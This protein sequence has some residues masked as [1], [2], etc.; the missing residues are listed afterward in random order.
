[1]FKVVIADLEPIQRKSIRTVLQEGFRRQIIVFETD[2]GQEAYQL[3][4]DNQIDLVILDY[5]LIG[6]DGLT[7]L[8]RMKQNKP[9]QKVIVY[10]MLDD[11]A[12]KGAFKAAGVTKFISKPLR[13]KFLLGVLSQALIETPE[14]P[15]RKVN[16]KIHEIVQFIDNHLHEDLTLTYV[17]NKMEL[18]PY[19]LSK[20]FKKELGINFIKYI[21][22]RKI[23]KAKELLRNNEI[24]IV[25][26]AFEIGFPEP[27]YFT[28]V[29]KRVENMTPSQYRN[30][31]LR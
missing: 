30:Q 7:T 20:V 19:Y 25:T 1:M 17:A 15:M 28:K 5:R 10:T 9:W 21:T 22:E 12:I 24:P 29:F 13:P 31:F 8:K 23:D 26:I 27:S 14:Q 11:P 4:Q 2:Q 16:L 6:V 3:V 18:S